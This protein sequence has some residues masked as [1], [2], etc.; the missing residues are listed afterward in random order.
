MIEIGKV[1]AIFE[2]VKLVVNV[3]LAK[4]GHLA[5]YIS[6]IFDLFILSQSNALRLCYNKNSRRIFYLW[7]QISS[8][9]WL[10]RKSTGENP[11][12][13]FH[14]RWTASK[15]NVKAHFCTPLITKT[16]SIHNQSP[17]MHE[18][19]DWL[20]STDRIMNRTSELFIWITK[21]VPPTKIP[22]TRAKIRK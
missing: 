19:I 1:S 4:V 6:S 12:N 15:S 14:M 5:D 18:K 22:Q 13:N 16:Q 17:H 2:F 11:P 21:N 8:H 7:H 9:F 20:A 3:F 10:R